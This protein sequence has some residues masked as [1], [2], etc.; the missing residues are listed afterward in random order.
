MKLDD[1]AVQSE[2]AIK[3][4]GP[5]YT[6]GLD[7][8]APNIRVA[9][10]VGAVDALSLGDGFRTRIQEHADELYEALKLTRIT[11]D[12]LFRRRTVT[13]SVVADDLSHLCSLSTPEEIRRQVL[14]IRRR[15]RLLK[16]ALE[17]EQEAIY[18]ARSELKEEDKQERDR[19]DARRQDLYAMLQAV[20]GASGYLTDVPGTLMADNASLLVLGS[21]G[22]GKTHFMCDLART[23]LAQGT[24]ALLVLAS[25]LHPGRDPLDAVAV[26]TGLA[27]DGGKLLKQLDALGAKNKRR[28][29]ILIDAINEG[30]R[31][32]WRRSAASVVR[33]IREYKNVGLILTCRTPFDRTIFSDRSRAPFVSAEH[34]G[35]EEQ[36]FDAQ[37]EFFSYYSIPAPHVP[38]ITQEF[39]RPLFLKLLCEALARLSRRSRSRKLREISSGQKGM[40]YVLEY[41]VTKIGADIERDFGLPPKTC[42]M[43][44]KGK[45]HAGHPGVAGVMASYSRDWVSAADAVA[46]M[47]TQTA[48]T[49]TRALLDRFVTDGLLSESAAYDGTAWVD[50]L[51][52]PYQRF[53]DHL[54]ARHL[55]EAYLDTSSEPSVRRCFYAN[56]PLG[57]IFVLDRWRTEFREPGLA[58]AIMLEF[59]ERMKRTGLN[60][61]L[62]GYLPKGRRLVMPVKDV[63]LEGLYW[64]SADSFTSETD[65]LIGFLLGLDDDRIRSETLEVLVALAARAGHPYN[66]SRLQ[67]Y[68]SAMSLVGRDL[69]WTEYIRTAGDLG[70][71]HR[72]LKW[73]ER[74][75][76]V[77]APRRVIDN[78][79]RLLSLGLTTTERVLRDRLTRALFEIGLRHPRVFFDRVLDSLA[80]NDPYV[81]ERMLAAA[82][83]V[84]MRLWADPKG[85]RLRAA[86][87]PFARALVRE[88]FLPA[89]PYGTLH[90]LMR[91]YALGIIDLGRRVASTAIATQYVRYLKQPMTHLRSPFRPASQ[92]TEA[93][94]ADASKALHMDFENYTIGSLIPQRANY[95]MGDADYAAVRKQILDRMRNLGYDSS[96]FESIDTEIGRYSW[97]A[98]ESGKTDRYGK[99]YSWI[100]YFEMY[101]LRD[102]RG[103]LPEWRQGERTP[104]CDIDPSFPGPPREWKPQL[105]RPIRNAP[106]EPA[107]WLVDGPVPNYRS[108]LRRTSVDRQQGPWV[109]LDGYVTQAGDHDRETFT[110][111][112]SALVSERNF[113][114]LKGLFEQSAHLGNNRIPEPASD[115]YTYM[116]EIPWSTRY[117][118]DMRTPRGK[119]RR[120]IDQAFLG[121]ERGKWSGI[122]VEI[123]V[124][125]WAWESYHSELTQLGSV[126]FPSPAVCEAL[127]LVNHNGSL[128]LRDDSGQLATIYCEW[129]NENGGFFGS[130]LLY[131]R[132]DLIAR[133]LH[134]TKQRLVWVSW[135]ERT[136]HYEAFQR[137]LAPEVEAA[138]RNRLDTYGGLVTWDPLQR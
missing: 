54:V 119:A 80:F 76:H 64:R 21:W 56:R 137:P 121:Y 111:L 89:A 67:D 23:A 105:P 71:L 128:D 17:R 34:F 47:Q 130:H 95:D 37:V 30:D 109:L 106:T 125:R 135:G 134:E 7:P 101:G 124:H 41:F 35:F 68:L 60:R 33:R 75:S 84:A 117:G 82:Y 52:F 40:T 131:I 24:P 32:V 51:I 97:R 39:S 57:K 19:L 11:M 123:P 6:P 85:D 50:V 3:A 115:Y 88:M 116:G 38:L 132:E 12:S 120:H 66:A 87:V 98:T 93:D 18:E 74:R 44:L 118:P 77:R 2:R 138:R 129:P 96:R 61:E 46:E 86:L 43:I 69:E 14:L 108:L 36:E 79:I 13:P 70:A 63:L 45:P 83:G 126:T 133:Y 104:D 49:S 26:V 28:S 1:L 110:F 65:R 62:L 5:R 78:D 92:L 8:K 102:D 91:G 100:A 122:P 107:A 4:A 81:P 48:L 114:R 9:H 42:W 55:L 20:S 29:L 103:Q 113:D 112:A 27:A 16:K 15:C 25:S 10:L 136:L 22:T 127:G 53:G 73:I 31:E 72:I 94:I 99:K 58:A 59:P 90:T